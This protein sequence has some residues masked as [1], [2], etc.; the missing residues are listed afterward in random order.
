MSILFIAE[1]DPLMSRM[2]ERAFRL[3]GHDLTMAGDGE[4]ALATLAKMDPKPT[5]VMLD[6][7]MPKMSGFDVLRKIKADEKVKNIPVILLTNLAGAQDAEKGLQLGAIMYLVKSQY[8]P[9]QVVEKVEEIIKASSRGEGVPEVKVEVK[10]IPIPPA[11]VPPP[12]P[13]PTP[14]A[15]PPIQAPPPQVL[16]PAPSPT[17]AQSP[18]PSVSPAIVGAPIPPPPS[19]QPPTAPASIPVTPPEEKK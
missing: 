15:P 16:T 3:G 10:D 7:M 11:P 12:S 6:V 9:K 13:A 8:N 2:Y 19:P 4:E 17:P 14:V 5:L 1:D 18:M